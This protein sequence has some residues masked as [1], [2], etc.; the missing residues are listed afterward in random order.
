MVTKIIFD[1]L[2][3]GLGNFIILHSYRQ[4]QHRRQNQ[5]AVTTLPQDIQ[6]ICTS[7]I[8]C[9]NVKL[10]LIRKNMIIQLIFVRLELNMILN[11][12]YTKMTNTYKNK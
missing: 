8:S 9:Y 6:P 11:E 1:K 4:M 10:C 12:K 2:V 3:Y 7:F 5:Y